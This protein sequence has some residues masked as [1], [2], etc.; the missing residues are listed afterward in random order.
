MDSSQETDLPSLYS[1]RVSFAPASERWETEPNGVLQYANLLPIDE[2]MKGTSWHPNDDVDWYRMRLDRRGILVLSYFRPFGTGSTE[3]K[4]KGADGV[5]IAGDSA[6]VFT[7]QK[8]TI[9]AS[10]NLGDYLVVVDPENEADA[11]AEYQLVA[12]VLDLVA[13]EVERE[14]TDLE[15]I[16]PLLYAAKKAIG[17]KHLTEYEARDTARQEYSKEN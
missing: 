11:S 8:A 2:V 12:T 10:L 3:I 1:F 4:L 5:D 6:G 9:S 14:I 13:L 7:G 16:D 17:P 15:V